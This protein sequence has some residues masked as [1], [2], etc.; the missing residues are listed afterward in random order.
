MLTADLA[1]SRTR[2]R[3]VRPLFIDI[4]DEQYRS[5]AATL[6]DL[7]ENHLGEPK[8]EL[9]TAIDDLTVDNTDYKI[10]QGLAKLLKDEC[11]FEQQAAVDPQ[12]IRQRYSSARTDAIRSFANPHSGKTHRNSKCTVLSL[13]NSESPSKSVTEGC[14]RIWTTTSS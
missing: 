14:T 10:V 2:G 3:E 8:G 6:I 13:T 5:T 11:E 9:E 12:E 1:R 4:S 7:F